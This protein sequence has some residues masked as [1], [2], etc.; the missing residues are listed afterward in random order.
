MNKRIVF[1]C[2]IFLTTVCMMAQSNPPANATKE[3]WYIICQFTSGGE[4]EDVSEPMEIAF[5]GE[6]VYFNFPNPVTGNTWMMGTRDGA[7]VEFERGQ[8]VGT[9]GGSKIYYMGLNEDGLCDIAFTYNETAEAF[10]LGDMWLALT[11]SL[12]Q[13]TALGYFSP[14]IITKTSPS[15]TG[16]GTAYT[17]TG[18]NVNPNNEEQY[19]DLSEDVTVR[20]EGS[21]VSIQGLSAFD[22]SVTLKGT[23]ANG[24][25]TCTT[26]QSAGSYNN[27]P[28]YFIGYDGS[29]CDI[30]FSYDESTGVL[31]AGQYILCVTES[32]ITY[33][34]LKDIL[35]A[36]KGSGTG[37]TPEVVTPPAGLQTS[38]YIFTGTQMLTNDEGNYT[39]YEEVKYNVRVGFYNNTAVYIQGLCRYLPE[40]WVMGTIGEEFLG[41]KPITFAAGQYYG[42]YGLYPLYMVA[43]YNNGL[44]DMVYNYDPQTREFTNDGGYYLVLNVMPDQPAPVEMFVYSTMKPGTYNG[45][46][47][48]TAQNGSDEACY[49]LQGIR[50]HKPAKGIYIYQGKKIIR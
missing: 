19:E 5:D 30:T 44:T 25:V 32:G 26:R 24:V 39:G 27:T 34:L 37:S 49:S 7:T 8:L 47:D 4:S 35:L 10:I 14:V 6:D 38:P 36:P 9:Y 31:I 20:F 23:L 16:D 3:T 42:Q 43:R 22:S 11:N 18:K 50:V 13:T 41:D 40:A 46:E 17:M 1:F 12:T 29:E 21:E 48:I 2:T 45:I 28:L 33:Q 15:E